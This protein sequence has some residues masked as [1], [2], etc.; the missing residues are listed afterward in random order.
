[1]ARGASSAIVARRRG[2]LLDGWIEIRG[3]ARTLGGGDRRL[4]LYEKFTAA[5]A[6]AVDGP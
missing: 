2:E 4:F 6:A 1:M 3:D 5:T